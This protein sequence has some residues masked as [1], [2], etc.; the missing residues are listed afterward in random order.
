MNQ[1]N[2]K[3][4]FIAAAVV[5]LILLLYA[6]YD[7]GTRTT[8]PGTKS[9]TVVDREDHPECTENTKDTVSNLTLKPKN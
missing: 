2:Q 4:F 9:H 6:S 3:K 1:K 7:M 8:F 5:F